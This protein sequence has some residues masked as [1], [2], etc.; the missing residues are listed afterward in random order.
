[1]ARARH[2]RR[3]H[4]L[5]GWTSGF[6]A[7]LL[8]TTAC[9]KLG[10]RLD[11]GAP[12]AAPRD[13]GRRDGLA[14]RDA[15]LDALLGTWQAA[16]SPT[17]EDLVAIWGRSASELW[18]VGESGAI[19]RYDGAAWRLETRVNAALSGVAG[20]A[21]EVYAVGSPAAV[22]RL[23]VGTW[24]RLVV[25]GLSTER[26]RA[27]HSPTPGEVW[28]AGAGLGAGSGLALRLREGQWLR[29]N[30]GPPPSAF[31]AIW[32][33]GS[34]MPLWALGENNGTLFRL[35]GQ[36]W[37][38]AAIPTS[39]PLLRLG[40]RSASDAWA[41]GRDGVVAHHDGA[42]WTASGTLLPGG[43]L[44]GVVGLSAA[45]AW[46]VGEL[47][48][49]AAAVRFDGRSWRVVGLPA[50]AGLRDVWGA[51]PTELWAVGLRGTLLHYQLVR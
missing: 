19:L 43:A 29:T 35:S 26:L 21:T 12:D 5:L 46:A 38:A 7:L 36:A 22:Y 18:A 45:E 8:A 23:A 28:V 20:N 25:P 32:S 6:A 24:Q 49:A 47:A 14:P 34:Q 1:M 42:T 39:L 40:G 16:A 9:E 2:P 31:I 48:G 50:A 30:L 44:H 15:A 17:L 4:R 51:S 33:G 27:V 37:A 13:G 3:A 41:V 10:G 11:G